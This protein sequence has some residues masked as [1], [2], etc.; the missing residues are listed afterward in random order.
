MLFRSRIGGERSRTSGEVPPA[1]IPV[2]FEG[3]PEDIASTVRFVCSPSARFLT[4]QNIHV[5]GGQVLI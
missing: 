5:N 1:E 2:G 4:G 3:D